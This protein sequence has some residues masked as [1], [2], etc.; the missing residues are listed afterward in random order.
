MWHWGCVLAT[1]KLSTDLMWWDDFYHGKAR[2][3]HNPSHFISQGILLMGQ[4]HKSNRK[5]FHE[6]SRVARCDKNE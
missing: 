1:G 6:W 3:H 4:L 5:L 2:A